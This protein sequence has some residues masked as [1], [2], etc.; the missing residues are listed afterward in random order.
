MEIHSSPLLTNPTPLDLAPISSYPVSGFHL[1][2]PLPV[3]ADR[4]PCLNKFLSYAC[5]IFWSRGDSRC[6][7]TETGTKS[8]D[9][10]SAGEEEGRH[11]E[12]TLDQTAQHKSVLVPLAQSQGISEVLAEPQSSASPKSFSHCSSDALR[13]DLLP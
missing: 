11:I 12:T 10:R 7:V 5:S 2:D 3:V 4:F 1:A 13:R 8:F 9:Q 6:F